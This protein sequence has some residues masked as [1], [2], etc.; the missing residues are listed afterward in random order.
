MRHSM[1]Y[2]EK[3]EYAQSFK[4]HGEK[5]LLYIEK[6]EITGY[7]AGSL[8]DCLCDNFANT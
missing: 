2:E 5:I 7:L 8:E 4:Q 6:Y 3:I 1:E